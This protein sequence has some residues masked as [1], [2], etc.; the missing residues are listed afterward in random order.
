MATSIVERNSFSSRSMR[1]PSSPE[2]PQ[3]RQKLTVA[4]A[5]RNLSAHISLIQSHDR[6]I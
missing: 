5:S 1:S 3:D 4:P 2:R 6:Q